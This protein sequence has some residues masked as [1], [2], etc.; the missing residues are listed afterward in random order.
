[1]SDVNPGR[2]LFRFTLP[3]ALILL[4]PVP[5]SHAES[6]ADWMTES[7]ILAAE[8][9][10]LK[11]R[12]KLVADATPLKWTAP[13][14]NPNVQTPYEIDFAASYSIQDLPEPIR[15]LSQ[16]PWFDTYPRPVPMGTPFSPTLATEPVLQIR[17][18]DF[19]EFTTQHETLYSSAAALI[20]DPQ[21]DPFL[22][23]TLNVNDLHWSNRTSEPAFYT[24]IDHTS[25]V[26]MNR[27]P[28]FLLRLKLPPKKGVFTLILNE[29]QS[30]A[31]RAFVLEKLTGDADRWNKVRAEWAAIAA[32]PHPELGLNEFDQF[33]NAV[34]KALREEHH[35]P[36]DM[37]LY[38]QTFVS[39]PL[40]VGEAQIM[41]SAWPVFYEREV[42]R[43]TEVVQVFDRMR[44]LVQ[45]DENGVNYSR[46]APVT[47]A[48]VKIV[49]RFPTLLDATNV[50]RDPAFM[51]EAC[52]QLG[53]DSSIFY[54][55]LYQPLDQFAVGVGSEDLLARFRKDT[56][57]T[58]A[59]AR[60][61]MGQHLIDYAR[62][63]LLKAN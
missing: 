31:E 6:C 20:G 11:S 58:A 2:S 30:E 59:E 26:M 36:V 53:V 17:V 15:E 29:P 56:K 57:V 52:R 40:N 43:G 28:N 42:L 32:S 48:F 45:A 8:R 41:T 54:G 33:Q 39:R 44:S 24:Q 37:L 50:V 49:N 13:K 46:Y 5:L 60:T 16:K 18:L 9:V 34:I 22:H 27:P 51:T 12:W 35:L 55:Q 3:I 47:G 21:S 61:W 1:M 23:G 63:H 10:Q 38:L 25:S 4:T 62:N 19:G 14:R 7:S